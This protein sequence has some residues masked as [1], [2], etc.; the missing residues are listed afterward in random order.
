MMIISVI[1][2][3]RKA[4]GICIFFLSVLKQRGRQLEICCGAGHASF[5]ISRA[6]FLVINPLYEMHPNGNRVML[7]RR[8]PSLALHNEYP[9]SEA[10][11][12]VQAEINKIILENLEAAAE[13]DQVRQLRKQFVLIDV[14]HRYCRG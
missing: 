14:P 9:I 12:P 6:V 7:N 2:S 10:Y 13:D 11:L 8:F 4:S 1:A 3:H 5:V